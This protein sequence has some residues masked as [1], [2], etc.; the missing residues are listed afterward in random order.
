M[1]L[2]ALLCG[3][4]ALATAGTAS[5]ADLVTNGTFSAGFTGYATTYSGTD[6]TGTQYLDTNPRNIC[7]C[8]ASIDGTTNGHGNQLILDGAIDGLSFFQQTVN[9]VAG[10][11]YS[12]SFDAANLG[13]A[14]PIPNIAASVNGV[15]LFT[16][17][18][19]PYDDTY[20][21]YSGTFVAG[22]LM[23]TATLSLADQTMDHQY[24]DFAIDNVA[25]TGPAPTGTVPEPA[26]WAM[27]LA[28]FGIVGGVMRRRAGVV[29]VAA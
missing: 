2:N 22:P 25:F 21:T 13:T 26:S 28:G 23:H 17:G 18:N 4:L 19:L 1:K 24:N 29:S 14:G 3:A 27:M 20:R 7:G 11:T 8:F 5:A 16:S 6:V 10:A 9:I 15:T 12:F